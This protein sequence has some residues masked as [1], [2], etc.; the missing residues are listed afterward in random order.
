MVY[1]GELLKL[2]GKAFR[3]ITAYKVGRNKLWSSDTGRNM[4]GSM[5]GTLVGNFP[6]IMLEIEPLEAEE[7]AELE[8]IFDSVSITVEYY[9]VKQ[10]CMCRGQFYSNDYEEDLFLSLYPRM[11]YKSFTV[12]LISSESEEHHVKL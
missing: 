11:K 10:K 3:C 9:N 2:N 5:K 8:K 7:M 12:N 4:A 6:K 1:N